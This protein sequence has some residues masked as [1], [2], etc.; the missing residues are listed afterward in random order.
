MNSLD[1]SDS[2][3]DDYENALVALAD[4]DQDEARKYL[5]RML[6]RNPDD[7]RSAEI[8]GDFA[9]LRGDAA[10]A[11]K[12]YR[13]MVD[14]SEDPSVHGL[15]H[16]S[17]GILYTELGRV[18]EAA[19]CIRQAA[20]LF[21]AT[22]STTQLLHAL[23]A[24][25]HNY[26]ERGKLAE[27]AEVFERSLTFARTAL[28]ELGEE[29]DFSNEQLNNQEDAWDSEDFGLSVDEELEE[30]LY[31]RQ[32]AEDT[33]ANLEMELGQLYRMLGRLDEAATQ[34]NSAYARFE[35]WEDTAGRATALDCLGVLRQVQGRY[36]EAEELLL[37]AIEL[38]RQDENTEGLAVNY[39]NMAFLY[40]HR[41]DFARAEE[42]LTQSHEILAEP[43]RQDALAG[44]YVMR[45]SLR[46]EADRFDE[47]E[48]DLLKGLKL[49]KQVYDIA[50][51]AAA[52]S[53]LA[54]VYRRT[55]QLEE[56]ERLYFKVLKASEE[57][58]QLDFQAS[59]LDELGLLRK[60]QGR[61]EEA[62][63]FW[64]RSL[65]LYQQLESQRMIAEV[66]EQLR[67]LD[68]G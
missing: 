23:T 45:G 47:A 33:L 41:K 38:N 43:D 22:G 35:S 25:G 2:M 7:Y 29:D 67:S 56:A 17:V 62:R 44:Y 6:D 36:D 15:S 11:E 20:M 49:H 37:E 14:L 64:Q 55:G 58:G 9:R 24:L 46:C 1:P 5:K 57:M 68:A 16:M 53:H 31:E 27:A 39:G 12:H 32:A 52:E 63:E 42:Y 60:D 3:Q 10:N 19:D 61:P 13:R 8:S 40:Q 66:A 26:A 28:E 65:A 30:L 18:E 48:Q 21:E 54:I 51:I 59:T 50:G 34:L 4:E